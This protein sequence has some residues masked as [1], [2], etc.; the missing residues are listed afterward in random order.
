MAGRIR[1]KLLQARIPPETRAEDL[2]CPLCDRIIPPGHADAHH[3]V[4]KSKGG[5]QTR[6]LHRICHRQIHALLTETELARQFHSIEALRA[7]PPLAQFLVW[8]QRKPPDFN[9]RTR[10]SGRLRQR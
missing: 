6:Y 7:H 3:L 8:V 5:V 1:R 2:F 10:K 4:P 9:E